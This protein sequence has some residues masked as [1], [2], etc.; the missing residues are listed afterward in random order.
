MRKIYNSGYKDPKMTNKIINRIVQIKNIIL[1]ST[2]LTEKKLLLIIYSFK[3]NISNKK[4]MQIKYT[5]M[6]KIKYLTI[7]IMIIKYLHEIMMIKNKKK[8][9]IE[10]INNKTK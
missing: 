9:N 7:K 4:R 2:S 6:L 1:N 3:K 10:L 5:S 8:N